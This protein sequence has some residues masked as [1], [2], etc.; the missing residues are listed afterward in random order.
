ML[1]A[2]VVVVVVVV[3]YLGGL[4][5]VDDTV[6]GLS[7]PVALLLGQTADRFHGGGYATD[8]V[9][10]CSSKA[11]I[12]NVVRARHTRARRRLS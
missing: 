4:V 2:A 10:A 6:R 3:V 9:T 8:A 1:A 11:G 5:V 12:G 7:A